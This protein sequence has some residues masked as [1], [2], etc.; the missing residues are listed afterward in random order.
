[1]GLDLPGQSAV[2][3]TKRTEGWVAGLQLAGLA[4][5]GRADAP[6]FIADFHGTDRYI[7]DYLLEE[8]LVQLPESTH[9]FLRQSSILDRLCG[10][11]CDA[12]MGR[13][14]SEAILRELERANLFLTPL[15]NTRTWYRYHQL[16]AEML[17]HRQQQV[18][19]A[20]TAHLHRRAAAWFE[21]EGWVEPAIGHALAGADLEHAGRLVEIS[22]EALVSRG[23]GT[24]LLGWLASLPEKVR[25]E[26][27]RLWL[28]ATWALLFT[29]RFDRTERWLQDLDR[30]LD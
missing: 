6:R 1:M 21:R 17:R 29:S 9:E 20:T 7:A 14:D 8:V 27:P 13:A 19:P 25:R 28:D 22:A 15:D 26:R 16:F 3:L 18:D 10:S 5:R 11:L 2:A 23:E 12:V 30:E 4:V 24:T